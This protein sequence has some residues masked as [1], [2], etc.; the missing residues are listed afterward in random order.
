MT[1]SPSASFSC[2]RRPSSSSAGGQL[3]HPSD[4]NS[5]TTT[6]FLAIGALAALARCMRG[7]TS[8]IIT[9][10][11]SS[12][13]RIQ[14]NFTLHILKCRSAMIAGRQLRSKNCEL[15]F[16]FV[17]HLDGPTGYGHRLDAELRLLQ[18]GLT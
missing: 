14:I 6:A 17:L 15:D 16:Q 9:P 13:I 5:S 12:R 1:S 4:V 8:A 2:R 7:S 3:E 10:T 18:F 11:S